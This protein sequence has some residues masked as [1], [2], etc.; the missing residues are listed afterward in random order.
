MWKSLL[1]DARDRGI[2]YNVD[3]NATPTTIKQFIIK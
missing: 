1:N 2:S 3:P